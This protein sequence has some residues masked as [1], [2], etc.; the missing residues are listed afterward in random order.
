LVQNALTLLHIEQRRR[1]QKVLNATG[2][3]LHTNLGRAALAPQAIAAL[4]D[5]T[6]YCNLEL[7]LAT[8]KRAN[9]LRGL[10]SGLATLTGAASAIAVNN[11]AAATVLVL[12]ALAC[13]QEV[14][15]SRGQLIEI[16]GSFRLPDIMTASGA[17]LREVGTTNITR[18]R[19]FE[20]AIGPNS[21][22]LLQ[23]HPSNYR[24]R[25]F[26][27]SVSTAELATL[28]RKH[29]IPV[30]DDIGSGLA[31][32]LSPW[33]LGTE[34]PTVRS[35]LAAGADLVL[36]SADKLLGGPQAGIIAGDAQRIQRIERD[37][38]FRAFRPDKLTLAALAATVEL[39]QNPTLAQQS[40]PTLRM[41]TLAPEVIRARA[42]Q[43]AAALGDGEVVASQGYVGGGS[44]PD[45]PLPSF[46][47]RLSNCQDRAARLRMQ[48][49]P[50]IGRV[51]R[52]A[53]WLD[54][55]TIAPEDDTALVAMVREVL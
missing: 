2:I 47:L 36:F 35:G 23:V 46:A 18:R 1:Y 24:V 20:A 55:R 41:L 13:G 45:V 38:L 42:E 16:G 31:L 27:Q 14:L 17:I 39:Y 52:D 19:D 5:V 12:R 43:W 53:L 15:V 28:G 40:I 29:G 49:L 3:V 48:R 34:E 22:M 6:G 26:V 21:G 37:P 44:L 11:C 4:L 7:D 32:H 50:V 51:H 30:V 25:G 9:R 54:P 33:K 8:G 10:R